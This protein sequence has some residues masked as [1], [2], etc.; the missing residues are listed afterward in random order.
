MDR[1]NRRNTSRSPTTSTPPPEYEEYNQA[2]FMQLPVETLDDDFSTMP[3]EQ[4]PPQ[5][6][7]IKQKAVPI[8]NPGITPGRTNDSNETL[9]ISSNTYRSESE[10]RPG[11]RSENTNE[12]FPDEDIPIQRD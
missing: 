11:F 3:V 1:Q 12:Q 8:P 7:R 5:P 6:Q 2:Q 10:I 9:Q 4:L